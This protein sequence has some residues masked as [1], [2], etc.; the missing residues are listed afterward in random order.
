MKIGL[1]GL[2]D[3]NEKIISYQLILLAFAIYVQS[4]KYHKQALILST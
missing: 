3:M 4:L 1:S 2:A